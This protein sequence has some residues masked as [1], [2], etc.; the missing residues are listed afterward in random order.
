MLVCE[1]SV[2][3]FG[4]SWY[5]INAEWR[6]YVP[7]RGTRNGPMMQTRSLDHIDVNFEVIASLLNT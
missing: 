2:I 5:A 3:A 6:Q 7:P 4:H 1:S